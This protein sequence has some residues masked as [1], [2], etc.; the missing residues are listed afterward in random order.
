MPENCPIC[1]T[2]L[3]NWSEP[4]QQGKVWTFYHCDHCEFEVG[5]QD[6]SLSPSLTTRQNTG[7]PVICAWC[8][9]SL[10]EK[11]GKG[12]TRTSHGICQNCI[13][14]ETHKIRMRRNLHG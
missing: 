1:G 3:E 11:D 12:E 14:V 4:D 13:D 9:C 6:E 10:G 7:M 5:F 8:G 2:K